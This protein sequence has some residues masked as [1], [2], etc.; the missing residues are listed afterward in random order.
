MLQSKTDIPNMQAT[1]Y[2]LHTI[3]YY[4]ILLQT[5]KICVIK[6][7]AGQ[8]HRYIVNKILRSYMIC[9]LQ[10]ITDILI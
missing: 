6:Y 5:Y 10:D 8:A 1:I 9:R 3:V 2:Y 7:I 4:N